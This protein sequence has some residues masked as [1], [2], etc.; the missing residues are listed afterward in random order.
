[1]QTL[2]EEFLAEVEAYLASSGIEPTP[3]GLR[4]LKDPRFVFDLRKGRACSSRTIDRVRGFMRANPPPQP[5]PTEV[6]A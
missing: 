5:A 2:Q 3:F 6:A 4:A 1:M